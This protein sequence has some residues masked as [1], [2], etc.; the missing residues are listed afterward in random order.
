M[1]SWAD[2]R[3]IKV[4]ILTSVHPVFDARIFHKEAK[5]LAK[6]GYEVV[7]IA[8]HNSEET[9]DGVRII[10]LPAPKNRFERVTKTVWKLF[11]AAL[12]EKADVYHFHDPELIPFGLVLKLFGKKVIYDVHE[13]YAEVLPARSKLKAG[14]GVI[15]FIVK[16][17]LERIPSAIFDLLVFPTQSLEKEFGIPHKSLTLVNFPNI[18]NIKEIDDGPKWEQRKFDIIHLGTVSSQRM[19][20]M[21]SVAEQL[22]TVKDRFSW[23]FLGMSGKMINWVK[24]NYSRQF[25]E[26]HIVMV[27]KVPHLEA[28]KYVENSRIGFNYHP[29]EKRFLVSIPMK[30]FEYMLMSLAVVTTDLPELKKYLENDVALLIDSQ[31]PVRYSDAIKSLLDNPRKAWE[32]AAKAKRLV[33]EQLN[34]E[35]SDAGKLLQAYKNLIEGKLGK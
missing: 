29:C 20:F 9:V 2:K 16:L 21:L 1:E 5:T 17:F 11:R 6:G 4:C 10:P 28:L 12:K 3:Q 33:M 27:E 30:V 23:I 24:K 18:E 8:Q 25:L 34:W 15:R 19:S 35:K 13:Y 14:S 7:L 31:D 26:Q 32:M 22:S